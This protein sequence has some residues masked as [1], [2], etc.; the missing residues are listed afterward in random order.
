MEKQYI[1]GYV[2][3]SGRVIATNFTE[4]RDGDRVEVMGLDLKSFLKNPIM[5]FGHD[6][7]GLPIGKATNLKI[8]GKSLTFE[9]VFS[10][11]HELARS[12]KALWEEGV[13]KAVSIGF[14]PKERD[15]NIFTK[16]ELLEISVVN[17]PSNPDALA[18]AKAKGLDTSVLEKEVPAKQGLPLAPADTDW[19]ADQ[20]VTRLRKFAGGPDR[21]NMDWDTYKQAFAW[22]DEEDA[23]KFSAYKMPIA[24]VIDEELKAVPRAVFAAQAALLGARGGLDLPEEERRKVHNLLGTFYKKMDRE[25]PEFRG[26]TI[27][28]VMTLVDKG[29]LLPENGYHIL[30]AL[31][32]ETGESKNAAQ[33]D[34]LADA[35]HLAMQQIN[36]IS[37]F[38]LK[39]TND[40]KRK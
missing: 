5:L 4:D 21:E 12:V 8:E 1:E 9:P 6:H 31:H 32:Q 2:D 13:L 38:S 19:D 30:S 26:Y 7:H 40:V 25:Q 10:T 3:K 20:A 22:R 27:D 15:G 16:S 17:V 37:N 24:D 28:E 34:I 23:Q 39:T 11:A 14:I 18:M 35:L 29:S 36:K 33:E